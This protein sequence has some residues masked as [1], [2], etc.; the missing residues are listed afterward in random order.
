[1]IL[2]MLLGALI[3]I[4]GVAVGYLLKPKFITTVTGIDTQKPM[5]PRPFRQSKKL[6]PKAHDDE[7]LA[8]LE[9]K[10]KTGLEN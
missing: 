9:R 8:N 1:M 5:M 10:E 7:F 2:G 4:V 3:F 6:K